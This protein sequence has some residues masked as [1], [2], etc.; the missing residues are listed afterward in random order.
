MEFVYLRCYAFKCLVKNKCSHL[1]I[2]YTFLCFL[3]ERQE[4]VRNFTYPR[5]YPALKSVLAERYCFKILWSAVDKK[6]VGMIYSRSWFCH[7]GM[8]LS[9]G[10]NLF[11]SMSSNFR[12]ASSELANHFGA[13]ECCVRL[14][15]LVKLTQMGQDLAFLLS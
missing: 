5:L 12:G 9:A 7:Q 8:S 2:R 15:A 1:F 6:M 13:W 3:F 4:Y 14:F 11:I 10:Q